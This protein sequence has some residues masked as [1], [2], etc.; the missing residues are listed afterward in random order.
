MIY[1]HLIFMV[2]TSSIVTLIYPQKWLILTH[3]YAMITIVFVSASYIF[4]QLFKVIS[5]VFLFS[6]FKR[7][8]IWCCYFQITTIWLRERLLV[9]WIYYPGFNTSA[10]YHYELLNLIRLKAVTLKHI[11]NPKPYICVLYKNQMRQPLPLD[12]YLP[13]PADW[14]PRNKVSI[15]DFFLSDQKTR[16]RHR[17]V[18]YRFLFMK[19]IR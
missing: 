16:S 8:S 2:E 9:S 1:F 12:Y 14:P 4:E 17:I 10:I 6:I 18:N 3:I 19:W 5:S 11:I 13:N 7:F 15:S